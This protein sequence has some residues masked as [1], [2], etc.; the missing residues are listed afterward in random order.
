VLLLADWVLPVS[1]A[2]LADAGLRV[3]GEAISVVGPAAQL[4]ARY[5][6]EETMSFPGCALL[7][8]FVNTHTHLEL[9]AFQGFTRPSGF[10]H[11]MLRLLLARG[12]LDPTDYQASALWGAYE[13]LRCG[14]TSVG[15]TAYDGPAVARAAR[16]AGLRARVYQEVFGLD[17][18]V[19][20][21]AMERLE[22]AIDRIRNEATGATRTA[23]TWAAATQE[24][25]TPAA[26]P[27][28]EAGVSPHA[29]YTVSARLYREAARFA[30][31]AGLRLATHVAESAAEVE[32]LAKGTG[33]IPQTYRAARMWNA[34]GWTP[35]GV[36]PVSHVLGA[37]ALGPQT[38]VIHAVQVDG[39]DIGTLAASG[40]AVAHCPRSNARLRCGSAPV[41]AFLAAGVPVGLGTD[42]L[43][44]NDSLD[45]FVE[46]RAALRAAAERA[47]AGDS[48][49]ALTPERVLRI[50][51]LEGAAALGWA[52]RTGSLEPGKSA[53]V[54][55]VMLPSG[56]SARAAER[57]SP[58]GGGVADVL[59][60]SAQAVDVR[61]TMV[62]GRVLHEVGVAGGTGPPTVASGYLTARRKLGLK[63]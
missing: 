21:A 46:M 18:A 14:T 37:D 35:P 38:L 50:A 53:D 1:S 62:A 7:P 55:A 29:P 17:D 26:V 56:H 45:M 34:G 12:R 24:G 59:V 33:A 23:A 43:A 44:S 28:V 22:G 4:R 47:A 32:L 9:S 3:E 15:D 2:P 49:A 16:E 61:M 8:G 11:W 60:R 25:A 31:R 19:L 20:S 54:I 5:G 40:A 57:S 36:S 10:A 30:R 6:D 58:A 51:T 48:V 41:G 52:D 39:T 63:A 42:S 13:C 27:L